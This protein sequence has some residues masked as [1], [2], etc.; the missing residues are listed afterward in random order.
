MLYDD[1]PSRG[2]DACWYLLG[3]RREAWEPLLVLSPKQCIP[4]VVKLLLFYSLWI[5]KY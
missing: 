5:S 2:E 3:L 1:N 4:V